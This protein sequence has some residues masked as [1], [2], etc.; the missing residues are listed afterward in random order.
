MTYDFAVIGGGWA[1]LLSANELKNKYPNSKIIVFEA[2]DEHNLGGLLHSVMANGLTFDTGGP[3]ILFSRNKEV[4][5]KNLS[6]LGKNVYSKERKGAIFFENSFIDYPFENGIFSLEPQRRA[7]IAIGII[8][9]LLRLKSD[10]GWTPSNFYEWI[11]GFFG[12]EMGKTYLEP[13]NKKIWKRDLKEID[14]DWVFAPGRLPFPNLEDL[15]RAVAGIETTGYKEQ[16][17]FSYP[18]VGGIQ[19]MFDALLRIIRLKGIDYVPGTPVSFIK[20]LN[21]G[22]LINGSVE[23]KKIVNSIALPE[24]LRFIGLDEILQRFAKMFD[25]NSV[26]VVG[27]GF[28]GNGDDQHAVYVPD[29]NINFHRY[30]W[31]SNLTTDTPRGK[32][33][34]IAE[35]TVPSGKELDP[36]NI[37]ES[38]IEGLERVGI[39]NRNRTVIFKKAW[40]NKYGYPIYVKW[41]SKMRNELMESLHEMGILSV[42]RWGS[43]QYWNTDK[44]HEAV[45]SEMNFAGTI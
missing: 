5:E 20:R 29:P 19:A 32:S 10:P 36:E 27:V 6:F 31:M 11:Y 18:K 44:V 12:E 7:N 3:H 14:A 35:T 13:Y 34:L 24:F 38:T 21:T 8:N 30:T 2:S 42:G 41:H 45:L 40:V 4:L 37:M 39:I 17:I 1:G 16:A 33:N 9:C 26:V 25:Y 28:E 22:F 43:W 23:C 15:V